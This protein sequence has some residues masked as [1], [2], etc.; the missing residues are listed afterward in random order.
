MIIAG[1]VWMIAGA[2]I[3]RIGL[4][5]LASCTVSFWLLLPGAAVVFS[6]FY[7]GIFSNMYRKHHKRISAK[8]GANCPMGFLD[9][10]GWIIMAAM[11]TLGI[12]IRRYSLLPIWFIAMFYTGLGLALLITGVKFAL[13]RL[14]RR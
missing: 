11:M 13:A 4:M 9:M 10:R 1:A 14:P 3:L 7:F 6:A 2:N 8:T 5:C 12:V